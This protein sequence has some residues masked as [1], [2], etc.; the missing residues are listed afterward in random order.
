MH[1]QQNIIKLVLKYQ[2]TR[3]HIPEASNFWCLRC[4]NFGYQIFQCLTE[5]FCSDIVG[6]MADVLE[7]CRGLK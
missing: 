4:D 5:M 2:T 6:M 3:R 1:G 7:T